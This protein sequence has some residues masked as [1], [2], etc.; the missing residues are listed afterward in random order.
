MLRTGVY[1]LWKASECASLEI[2]G[3]G[4]AALRCLPLLDGNIVN[5]G[6]AR[7]YSA[8]AGEEEERV[9]TNP[10][11]LDLAE[12]IT[13]L[14]LLEVSDLTEILRKRLNIQAPAGGMGFGFPAGMPMAAAPAAGKYICG[15]FNE[16]SSMLNLTLKG[17]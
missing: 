13:Q 7:S 2:S 8:A 6:H 15:T 11:V 3:L 17:K 14:N 1:R 9:I 16:T 5:S 12:Q 10:K 4:Q